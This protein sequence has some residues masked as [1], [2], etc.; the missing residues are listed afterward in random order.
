M[1]GFDPAHAG[2][3]CDPPGGGGCQVRALGRKRR[4]RRCK[5][6]EVRVSNEADDDLAIGRRVGG[7]G[8][9][10]DFLAGGHRHCVA[11]PAERQLLS[12]AAGVAS[13][14]IG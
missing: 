5:G 2:V 1:E 6:Q 4:I 3:A 10:R 11:E 14:R 9:M 7:G 13:I 8:D 12:G